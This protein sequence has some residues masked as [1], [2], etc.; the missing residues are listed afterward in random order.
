[1]LQVEGVTVLVR[2]PVVPDCEAVQQKMFPFMTT[3]LICIRPEVIVFGQ[4]PPC[5]L[6]V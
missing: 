2:S 1:M 3:Y 5:R 4:D 6:A